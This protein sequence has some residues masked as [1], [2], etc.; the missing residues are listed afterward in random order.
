MIKNNLDYK[1]VN[2]VLIA[3]MIYFVYITNSF[4]VG[5]LSKIINIITPFIIAFALAHAFYPLL[6]KLKNKNIPKYISISFL[7]LFLLG[8]IGLIILLIIP[9]IFE[10]TS[11][12]FSGIIKFI[13]DISIQ[14]DI[15]LGTLQ[16]VLV[17]TF[18]AI[19]KNLSKYI[20]DGTFIII[21]K[22]LSIVSNT[23]IIVFVM[24]YLLIDMDKIRTRV[25]DYLK[26]SNMKTYNYIKLLDKEISK[27]FSGIGKTM[28]WQLFEYTILFYLIGHPHYLILGILGAITNVV[29]YLGAIITNIMAAITAF[30]ISKHLFILTI[31][32]ILVASTFDSYFV[33][34]KIFDNT[35][36]IPPLLTIFVIFAGGVIAGILGVI[37]ALPLTIIILNTYR[38]YKDDIYAIVKN[39]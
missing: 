16:Q 3:L 39:G 7:F 9:L 28:L 20:S 32:V 34:P 14:Y 17:D 19:I 13:S 31:I 37:V 1:L 25:E 8:L 30:A 24:L 21:N 22:S 10:Q 2:I 5:F 27:Y 36:K 29:P 35:N 26:N 33:S 6:I 11:G 23:I 38:F 4:W 12:L 18:N 15:D